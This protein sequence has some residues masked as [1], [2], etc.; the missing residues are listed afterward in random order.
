MLSIDEEMMAEMERD[1]QLADGG[2]RGRKRT[3]SRVM[4]TGP[5]AADR[6]HSL[7]LGHT[8]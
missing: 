7:N 8:V 2:K 6:R 1:E 5:Q 4:E 3:F